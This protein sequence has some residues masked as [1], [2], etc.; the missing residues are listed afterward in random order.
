MALCA[1]LRLEDMH[2]LSVGQVLGIVAE[3]AN[4]DV[5]WKQYATAEDI[6]HF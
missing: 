1:G 5:K 3:I 4:D 6:E 2:R